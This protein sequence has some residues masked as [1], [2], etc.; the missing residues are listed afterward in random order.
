[1]K[2]KYKKELLCLLVECIKNEILKKLDEHKSDDDMI[3]DNF[4]GLIISSIIFSS[5]IK[6]LKQKKKLLHNLF[7]S[8]FNFLSIHPNMV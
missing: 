3:L 6:I 5:I 8:F 2:I 1:M 4:K 7:F